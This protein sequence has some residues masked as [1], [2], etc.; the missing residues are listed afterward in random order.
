MKYQFHVLECNACCFETTKIISQSS[1]VPLCNEFV[2][3]CAGINGNGC[4][5]LGGVGIMH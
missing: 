5:G 4:L 2:R 3:R 1:V